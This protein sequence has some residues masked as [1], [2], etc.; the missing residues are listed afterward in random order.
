[1]SG[2][3]K[4]LIDNNDTSVDEITLFAF[5]AGLVF[6]FLEAWSV[7]YK[8]VAFDAL[9]FSGSVSTIVFAMGVAKRARSGV[10]P[11]QVP[12]TGATPVPTP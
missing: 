7:F 3:F 4:A 2:F 10:L 12:T 1:L 11:Q 8:G 9:S 5:M 6:I